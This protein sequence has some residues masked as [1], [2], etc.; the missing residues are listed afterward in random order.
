MWGGGL[1]EVQGSFPLGAVRYM[2]IQ[3][4]RKGVTNDGAY[5]RR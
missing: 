1:S 2:P 3:D 4:G 5:G